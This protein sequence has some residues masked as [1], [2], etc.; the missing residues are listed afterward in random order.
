MSGGGNKGAYQAAVIE[1][2][3]NLVEN[4]QENLAW[5]VVTGVSAGSLNTL[6]LAGF[7]ASDVENAAAFIYALWNSIPDY[8]AYGNWPGG[9]IQGLFFKTGIFDLQPGVDWV[10][11][12]WGNNVVK[13]KS[14][15]ATV[16]AN[17]AEYIVYDYNATDTLPDDFIQ[18]AF[19]SS[20][21]PG[22]FPHV[23]RGDKTLI[24][25]GVIWNLDVPSAIRRCK[26]IVDDEKDIIIDFILCGDHSL[27]EV[28]ELERY[29]TIDHLVRG[30]EIKSFFNGMSDYNSSMVLYP[31]VEFR[32]IIAPSENIQEGLLP[33]DFTRTQVDLCFGVG[34]KDAQSAV[35]LGS[36]GYGRVLLDYTERR[37]RGEYVKLH[38][39]IEE[40]LRPKS[41][42]S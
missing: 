10:T 32:Y 35:K 19:A 23:Q 13:R 29:D 14:S 1:E 15:F 33:L 39:M 42:S 37:K 17:K 8:N 7:E 26:E 28:A 40:A 20:S 41:V 36:G 31:D 11:E 12:K 9:I 3:V 5:D 4:P 18:S 34:K 24:D 30:I 38:D 6:G 2:L 22:V 21:I 16:D 25:G 27:A